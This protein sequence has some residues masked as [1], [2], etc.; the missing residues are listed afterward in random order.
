MTSGRAARTSID[1]RFQLDSVRLGEERFLFRR[2]GFNPLEA[3]LVITADEQ[4][5]VVRLTPVA[6]ELKAVVVHGRRSGVL[7][8]VTDIYDQPIANAEV[9]VLGG[10]SAT[11]TDSSGRFSLPSVPPGTFMVTV[12]KRGYFVL[13]HSVTLPFGEALDLQLLLAQVPSNLS[14]RRISRLAGFGGILDMAWDA[15]VTRRLRCTGANAVFVPREEIAELRGMQLDLAL[16]RAPSA[17]NRGFVPS[18]LRGYRVFI[19]GLDADSLNLSAIPADEVEAVEV[20]RGLRT[21]APTTIKPSSTTPTSPFFT[22]PGVCP[23]GSV[24]VW[25]R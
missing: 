9:T 13:R 1:G 19:D 8:M 12:R 24:W 2:L 6:E 22:M 17:L 15:H 3:T 25:L 5:I 18:E 23:S 16:Q 10:A 14:N 21:R 11:R 20:Y 4:E 7:G